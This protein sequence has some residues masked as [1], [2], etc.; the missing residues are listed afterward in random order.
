MK[1]NPKLRGIPVFNFIQEGVEAAAEASDFIIQKDQ[2][3]FED[4]INKK[5]KEL[6]HYIL[7]IE[8]GDDVSYAAGE[9]H[10]VLAES[11]QFY[12]DAEFYFKDKAAKWVK[13]AVR[14]KAIN[15][16]WAFTQEYQQAIKEKKKITFDYE[17]PTPC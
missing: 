10:L 8:K 13:K 15:I 17:R 16:A 2:G 1:R 6:D 5:A 12:L 14:G 3:S 7:A 4:Y 9:V 11:D